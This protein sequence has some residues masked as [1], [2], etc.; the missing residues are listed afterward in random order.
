M[1]LNSYQFVILHLYVL[2][3]WITGNNAVN[4]ALFSCTDWLFR[5]IRP[6]HIVGRLICY[7]Y[8]HKWAATDLH[9]MNH[10]GPRFQLKIFFNVLLKKKVILN[11]LRVSK[12][13]GIFHF[14]VNYSFNH[15]FCTI[16]IVCIY[17]KLSL[18]KIVTF[19]R[20][21]GFVTI[22]CP[23]QNLRPKAKFGYDS[24]YF[25]KHTNLI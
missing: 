22:W 15:M 11:G 5:F 8:S 25:C 24:L 23:I 16:Q 21:I 4:N 19:S 2:W 1:G 12:L 14:W 6:Q 7:F 20:E 18:H 9:F 17:T 10:Y 3:L 13:S